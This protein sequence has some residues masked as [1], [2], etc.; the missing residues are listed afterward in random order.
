MVAFEM[1]E[2]RVSGNKN[3]IPKT[4]FEAAVTDYNNALVNYNTQTSINQQNL[5]QVINR[6]GGDAAAGLLEDQLKNPTYVSTTDDN[7]KGVQLWTNGTTATAYNKYKNIS[8]SS[9]EELADKLKIIKNLARKDIK[10][11][12]LETSGLKDSLKATTGGDGDNDAVNDY[13]QSLIDAGVD[14]KLA[15]DNIDTRDGEYRDAKLQRKSYHLH[16]IVF[17]IIFIVVVGLV[18][19]A[20]LTEKTDFID[21]IIL[22]LGIALALYYLIEY[23]F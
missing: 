12:N 3:D 7:S 13:K 15:L 18:I 17:S 23:L 2:T 8:S 20:A 21:T 19:R 22:F 4:Q 9:T 14:Q 1:F 11:V 10:S 6:S 16:S 5:K